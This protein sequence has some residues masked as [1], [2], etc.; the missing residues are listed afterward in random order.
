MAI[1]INKENQLPLLCA[2]KLQM[3]Y[4]FELMFYSVQ[5]KQC[6]CISWLL[7]GAKEIGCV[8]FLLI[9]VASRFQLVV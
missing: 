7:E 4:E 9:L 2:R 6:H 3:C 5:H 1:R 8:S